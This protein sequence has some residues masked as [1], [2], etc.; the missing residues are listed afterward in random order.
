MLE[1]LAWPQLLGGADYIA[2]RPII[3]LVLSSGC[4]WNR[5]LFCPDRG[6]P[7]F[8]LPIHTV[9]RFLD[10]IPAERLAQKP[11]IHLL[12]AALPPKALR[13][14]LPLARDRGL[15]FF[16]FA[17]PTAHLLKDRL[18]EETAEAGCLMLQLGAEG[19][20]ASLLDR[21]DKGISPKESE[22]VVQ[23]AAAAGIRTYLYLLFGLPGE[24]PED[25]ARTLRW[26]RNLGPSVDFLNLSLF[27]LPRYCELAERAADFDIQ[28]GDYP[29]DTE[30]GI[31]MYRPFSSTQS[32][33][34]QAARVFLKTFR[35]DPMIRPAYLR[36]P[37]WFRAAHLAL[38]RLPNRREG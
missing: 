35:A 21:F 4:F 22:T 3:P 34:R 30:D 10:S 18:I 12:D 20:S 28:I 19:G 15:S 26:A 17:R 13:E 9:S 1:H 16:G 38:M 27:N 2:A 8:S 25:L 32:D 24:T 11:L 37:R 7:Y 23:R 36:T 31:R 5:C 29:E 14:F 33:P 6:T